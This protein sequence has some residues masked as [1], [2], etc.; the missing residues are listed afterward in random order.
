MPIFPIDSYNTGMRLK[1]LRTDYKLTILQL[2]H[3]LEC[4]KSSISNIET[5]RNRL[6]PEMM[7][8]YIRFFG[9]S[10]EWILGYSNIQYTEA[11][12]KY[13]EDSG[14]YIEDC[15]DDI[16][17]EYAHYALRKEHYSLYVRAN[18]LVIC[19][20]LA[21]SANPDILEIAMG[22][23]KNLIQLLNKDIQVPVYSH[24]AWEVEMLTPAIIHAFDKLDMVANSDYRSIEITSVMGYQEYYQMQLEDILH[25]CVGQYDAQI[26]VA[27]FF[28]EKIYE[29]LRARIEYIGTSD[30]LEEL[31]AIL[32]TAYENSHQYNTDDTEIQF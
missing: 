12:L 3:L 20:T 14:S 18:I 32:M 2:S 7:D 30:D 4:G 8:K 17:I 9:V 29:D 11:C 13:A 5:G 28:I 31:E 19:N 22:F 24:D 15:F 10:A 27:Q 26:G 21:H 6:S 23:G 16:P 25:F 1:D